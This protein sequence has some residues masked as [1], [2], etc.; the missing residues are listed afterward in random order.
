MTVTVARGN[1]AVDGVLHRLHVSVLRLGLFVVVE[2][3]WR[4]FSIE[5][6][7]DRRLPVAPNGIV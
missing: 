1:P 2:H 5:L 7:A 6:A 4:S 3:K